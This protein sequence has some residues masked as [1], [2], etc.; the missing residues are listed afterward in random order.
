MISTLIALLALLLIFAI[1]FAILRRMPL[2]DPFNWI[3]EILL[4]LILLLVLISWLLPLAG[5][6]HAWGWR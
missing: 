1:A 4:L 6:P 2:P 3:A 5:L